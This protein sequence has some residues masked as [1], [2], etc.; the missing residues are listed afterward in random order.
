MRCVGFLFIAAAVGIFLYGKTMLIKKERDEYSAVRS[1]LAF[2]KESLTGGRRTP[3]EAI[4]E[5]CERE[6]SCAIPWLSELRS[7]ERVNSFMRERRLLTLESYLSEEDK[8]CLCDFLF[9]FG[10]D[11]AEEEQRRLDGVISRF[12]ERER[13]IS[14][15]AEK[16]I[17]S[18]WVLFVTL[19]LGIF[20]LL[21]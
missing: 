19:A 18:A 13:E 2:L 3:R 11:V 17:K 1:M 15:A 14:A 5:F 10:R 7:G 6:E 21:L 9:D 8:T 20:I 16:N 12:L 4:T